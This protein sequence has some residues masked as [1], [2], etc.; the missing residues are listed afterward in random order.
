MFDRLFVTEYYVAAVIGGRVEGGFASVVAEGEGCV[1]LAAEL[2]DKAPA[3]VAAALD[4]DRG[5]V[6]PHE[7]HHLPQ[8]DTLVTLDVALD[9]VY[10]VHIGEERAS[11]PH[12][13]LEAYGVAT[14]VAAV[15]NE[16]AS[17]AEV[18]G[19]GDRVV[20][21]L[22]GAV[23]VAEGAVEDADIVAA[24]KVAAQHLADYGYGLHGIDP[25]LGADDARHG[26][27]IVSEVGSYVDGRVAGAQQPGQVVGILQCAGVAAAPERQ[28]EEVEAADGE[29]VCAQ[30]QQPVE[31]PVQ[32][33]IHTAPR[34]L[35]P[36][37]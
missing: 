12:L 21:H 33:P 34:C 16:V 31:K 32:Q 3:V 2:R 4:E 25:P 15:V 36:R 24:A 1:S 17:R 7:G 35:A 28:R 9:E 37:R 29:Q 27:R 10:A 14:D 22:D 5:V 6:A 26:P 19:R 30:R 23:A 11:A 8:N 13:R 20:G 18:S